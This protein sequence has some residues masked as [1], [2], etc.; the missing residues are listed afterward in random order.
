MNPKQKIQK[1]GKNLN[2]YK[3]LKKQ[4]NFKAQ[5]FC[6]IELKTKLEKKKKKKN[7]KCKK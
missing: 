1:N 7:Y 2:L 5:N 3:K 6:M 4:L